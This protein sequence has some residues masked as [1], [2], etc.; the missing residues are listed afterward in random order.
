MLQETIITA[1]TARGTTTTHLII[2]IIKPSCPAH[3]FYLSSFIHSGTASSLFFN[4][5]PKDLCHPS[6]ASSAIVRGLRGVTHTHTDWCVAIFWWRINP[7]HVTVYAVMTSIKPE[8]WWW[9]WWCNHWNYRKRKRM[10][11]TMCHLW[12]WHADPQRPSKIST[13]SIKLSLCT[14]TVIRGRKHELN[15]PKS[16][17]CNSLCN[18]E[19]TLT[20]TLTCLMQNMPLNLSQV[21]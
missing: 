16:G 18:A 10:T 19:L 21:F 13:A 4:P 14:W 5:I 8:L 7:K 6:L 17:R 11:S 12:V 9:L 3:F 2:K 20:H 15:H 1:Q